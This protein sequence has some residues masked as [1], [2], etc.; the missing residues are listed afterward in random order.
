MSYSLRIV[1][2]VA[3]LV[4]GWFGSRALSASPPQAV[5][6]STAEDELAELRR[7][8]AEGR[9]IQAQIDQLNARRTAGYEAVYGHARCRLGLPLSHPI[10][11]TGSV[12]E[13]APVTT[14]P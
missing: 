2:V 5:S 9:Q 1:L 10:R 12:L 8:D 11:W 4:A 6:V 14:K 7:L 13:V 3:A